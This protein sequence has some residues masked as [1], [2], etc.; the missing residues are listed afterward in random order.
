MWPRHVEFFTTSVPFVPSV[1]GGMRLI[2]PSTYSNEALQV[3]EN[4]PASPCD[5]VQTFEYAKRKKHMVFLQPHG[6]K[7]LKPHPKSKE[8]Y[9]FLSAVCCRHGQRCLRRDAH[10]WA[11]S[12]GSSRLVPMTGGE[13]HPDREGPGVR[14]GVQ[15]ARLAAEQTRSTV[16]WTNRQEHMFTHG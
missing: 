3:Q 1:G 5:L 12:V 10:R 2:H 9:H 13:G 6:L 15:R 8:M 16:Q 11:P 7:H 14:R 4:A